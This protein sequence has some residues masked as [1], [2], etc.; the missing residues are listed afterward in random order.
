M[1]MQFVP[2]PLMNPLHPSSRHIF[3]RLLPTD[4]WYASRPAL[5]TWNR[6]FSLS[7]GDTTVRDT[8][9]ATPP[10]QKAATTGCETA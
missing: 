9:P 4:S 2:L 7:S 5:W 8:A 6:I 10:A 3:A 1:R